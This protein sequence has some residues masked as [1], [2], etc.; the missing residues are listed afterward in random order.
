[1]KLFIGVKALIVHDGKVLLLR[2][3]VYDEG[4]NA[5]KWDVPGGRI[6]E[7]ESVLE[8]LAREMFEEAGLKNV[9]V[10]DVLGVYETFPVIKGEKCHIVRIFYAAY[11]TKMPGVV[12]SADHDAYEWVR[13]SDCADKVLV[14]NLE[15]LLEKV[16]G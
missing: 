13:L 7:G 9:R 6:N 2:E 4:T 15:Q 12:L 14:S 3:A 8:G 16:L 1:M 11:V 5:G 10:G